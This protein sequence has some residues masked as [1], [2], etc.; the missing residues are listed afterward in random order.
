MRKLS[1]LLILCWQPVGAVMRHHTLLKGFLSREIKGRFA[2]SFAGIMW[3]MI[4]PLATIIVYTFLFS[5]VVRIPI[6]AEETGTDIFLIYF[7]SGLFPWLMFSDGIARATMSLLG[8]AN[9]ITKVVFPVE[10]LPTSSFLAGA[11]IN[12]IGL[13]MFLGFLVVTGHGDLAWIV[14]PGLIALQ[15]I[16][17]WGLALLVSALTV[18]ITDMQE[19]IGIVLMVWFYGTPILYPLSLLPDWLRPA[20]QFNPA[21]LIVISYRDVLLLNVIHPASLVILLLYAVGMY[22]VGAIFFM[23]AK[24]AFGDVL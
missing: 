23:R 10:L 14:L 5:V 18:F 1:S 11:V 4:H 22:L 21:A 6:T 7:L 15:L 17:T 19:L 2:G 13:F 20:L 12:G 24:P 3:T 16:F 8:N 9:L